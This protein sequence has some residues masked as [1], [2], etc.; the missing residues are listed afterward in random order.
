MITKTL[1]LGDEYQDLFAEIYKA[2]STT[3]SPVPPV[4]INDMADYFQE[5]SKIKLLEGGKFLRLPLDEPLF[6]IDANTR[7]INV[8]VDFKSNGVAV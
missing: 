5:I 6:E 2:S 4:E 3:G 8:P 7:K 1:N